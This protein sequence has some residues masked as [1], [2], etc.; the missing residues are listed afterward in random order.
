MNSELLK[1]GNQIQKILGCAGDVPESELVTIKLP[2]DIAEFLSRK[3]GNDRGYLR[4]ILNE[5]VYSSIV[6]F[7][8]VPASSKKVLDEIIFDYLSGIAERGESC[9]EYDHVYFLK[10]CNQL[11]Q[12]C[13]DV[14]E[15]KLMEGGENV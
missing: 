4:L 5:G 11:F 15:K 9:V 13:F 7:F 8:D 6:N 12:S 2:R 3:I 1:E 10:G 14:L